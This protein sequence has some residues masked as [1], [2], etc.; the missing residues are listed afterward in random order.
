MMALRLGDIADPI[1]ERHRGREVA[2]LIRA[3][4]VTLRCQRPTRLELAE[5]R[6]D[7]VARQ[8]RHTAATRNALLIGERH[9]PLPCTSSAI[10]TLCFGGL[11]TCAIN[12]YSRRSDRVAAI[13]FGASTP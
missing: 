8:R 5:Q 11:Q 9:N 4:Q 2:K 13:E 1:G 3:Q 6:V 12:G 7:A 10:I